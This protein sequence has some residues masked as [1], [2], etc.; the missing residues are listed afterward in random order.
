MSMSYGGMF[1]E[2]SLK[3][4][5]CYIGCTLLTICSVLCKEP[6]ITILVC[7]TVIKFCCYYDVC[8]FVCWIFE[9]NSS[10]GLADVIIECVCVGHCREFA[11]LMTCW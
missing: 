10:Y 11:W 2:S 4:T 9:N 5:Y 7:C 8:F 6:G 1:S 3:K